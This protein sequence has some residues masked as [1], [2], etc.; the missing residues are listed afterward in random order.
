MWANMGLLSGEALEAVL[1]I[2]Q[3]PLRVYL[4]GVCL[5]PSSDNESS[6]L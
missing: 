2:E 4:L 1:H 3:H 5:G 6:I